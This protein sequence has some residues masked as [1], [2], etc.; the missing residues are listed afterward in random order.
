MSAIT[1]DLGARSRSLAHR[2]M[3]GRLRYGVLL[4]LIAAWLLVAIVV[5]LGTASGIVWF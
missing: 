2:L 3:Q 5:A 1:R 4:G